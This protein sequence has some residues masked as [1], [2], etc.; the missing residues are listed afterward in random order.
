MDWVSLGSAVV[1]IIGGGYGAF[2]KAKEKRLKAATEAAVEAAVV[3]LEREA[4]DM[5][6]TFRKSLA[7]MNSDVGGAALLAELEVKRQRAIT[8]GREMALKTYREKMEKR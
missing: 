6:E 7:K 1:G 8:K 3:E 2:K 5:M 4:E